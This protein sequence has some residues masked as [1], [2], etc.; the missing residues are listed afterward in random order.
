MLKVLVP[1][2]GSKSA[3]RAVSHL[4]RLSKDGKPMELHLLHVREP[5]LYIELLLGSTQKAVEHWGQAASTK[6]TRSAPGGRG[7]RRAKPNCRPV[8]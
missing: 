6:A 2:E 4:I 5:L 3:E 1:V 8:S 7:E